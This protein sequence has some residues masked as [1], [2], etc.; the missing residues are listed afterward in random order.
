MLSRA[1]DVGRLFQY[2]RLS[3]PRLVQ[4]CV[5]LSLCDPHTVFVRFTMADEVDVYKRYEFVGK[6][7]FYGSV[8]R[9]GGYVR[10][11]FS[12]LVKKRR[13]GNFICW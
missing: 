6:R 7:G 12:C 9:H 10:K 13:L 8:V 11:K 1:F 5:Q 4:L 2:L 3:H